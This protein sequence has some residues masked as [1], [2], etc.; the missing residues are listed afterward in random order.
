LTSRVAIIEFD[1]DNVK[2]SLKR[3]TDLIGGIENLNTTKRTVIVKVGVFSHKVKN[4]ASVAVVDAII[5]LFDKAHNVYLV[6]SDNYQGTGSERLQLWRELFTERVTPVNLSDDPKPKKVKLAGVDVN[7]PSVLLKP[8]VLVDTH[9]LRSFESG[10]ILKNLFGCILDSKRVKYHKMLPTLLA[11]V[12]EA[13][14]GVDLAVLDGTYFWHGAGSQP[15]QV[16]TL[17]IGRDAVAVETVGAVL[18]G[19]DPQKMPVIQEFVKRNLGE[20]NIESIEILGASFKD[21]KGKFRSATMTRK[22]ARL[23]GPQTW[24]GQAYRVFNELIQEGFFKQPNKRAIDDVVKAL[25][26][27]GLPTQ[28]KEGKIMDILARRT[29]RGILKKAKSPDGQIYWTE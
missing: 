1:A 22:K 4:H 27:K 18:A 26:R 6:E 15:V 2:E 25:E 20:G 8:K 14:G 23:K 7:L 9:I 10:S 19:L 11:D 3:A 21:V 24:G 16:N 5:N 17:I 29:K 12:Y 28:N 13:I